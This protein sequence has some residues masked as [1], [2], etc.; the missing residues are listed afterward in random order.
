MTFPPGSSAVYLASTSK[1]VV[2][3]TQP[4]VDLVQALVAESIQVP[5]QV[6][7][8]SKFIDISQTNLKELGFDWTLGQFNIDS[9]EKT[10]ASGGTDGAGGVATSGQSFPFNN[11]ATAIGGNP[12][13]S[14]NRSGSFAISANAVDALLM[15]SG[16]AAVAPGIFSIAGVFSDPQFQVVIRALNQ[17]KG[18]DL[19]SAPR[20]TAK[21]GQKATI[22]II[23]EF[24]YPTQFQPPQIP[25]TIGATSG[26]VSLGRARATRLPSR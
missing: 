15:G 14:G 5:K 22:E 19:L 26:G 3:N 24:I 21:S 8:E 2:R 7:I 11:N 20:V 17:Q 16:A 6:E 12:V 13:T 23:R 10:F 9:G 18:V 25:Q 4:N 1:L